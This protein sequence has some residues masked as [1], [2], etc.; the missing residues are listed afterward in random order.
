EPEENQKLTAETEEK[1]TIDTDEGLED[2]EIPISDLSGFSQEILDTLKA[3]GFETLAELSVTPL[4]ELVA[5]D[6]IDENL[7]TEI[8][9]KVKQQLG[10]VENV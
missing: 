3:N 2:E 9:A 1:D 10:N 4:D 7:G 6:G 8:L 5:I